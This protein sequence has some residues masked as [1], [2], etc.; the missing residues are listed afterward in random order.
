MTQFDKNPK[1]VHCD[2]TLGT[3]LKFHMVSFPI[4]H[5]LNTEGSAKS[6]GPGTQPGHAASLF[7]ALSPTQTGLLN[8]PAVL[9]VCNMLLSEPKTNIGHYASFFEHR[10]KVQ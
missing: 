9:L 5:T 6:Y 8:V 7:P 3:C 1:D 2:F 4:T 10:E